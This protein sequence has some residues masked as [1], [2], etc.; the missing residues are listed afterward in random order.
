M[1]Q[2]RNSFQAE[3][4]QFALPH[5]SGDGTFQ[6]SVS[7]VEHRTAETRDVPILFILDA[8]IEF[9]LAAEIARF[10]G[11]SGL[12][13]TAM[14]VGVGYGAAYADMAKKRTADLTPPLSA[15]GKASV[16]ELAQLIGDRDGGAEAQLDFL[17]GPLRREILDRYPEASRT[18]HY[19]FGHSLGGLF[20]AYALLTRP[21][22]FAGFLAA[23]PSLWWD[24][25]AIL[26][27]LPAFRQKIAELSTPPIAFVCAGE[28]EQDVPDKVPSVLPIPL[29]E[30]QAMV[31]RY[32]IVDA[33]AEF[34]TALR[35]TGLPDAVHVTFAD[36]DHGT[37][38]APAINRALALVV[39]APD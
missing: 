16:G 13:P 1:N 30:L 36:E 7:R 3:I 15:A 24:E 19:L 28:K 14:V 4:E 33:A 17:T 20:T 5:P 10:R 2:T 11:I 22:S 32:R 26:A 34:A 6:I 25:F 12:V 21:E 8:D 18:R 9:A 31:A 37:V 38:V 39:P 29:E 35:E 27:L 23:S